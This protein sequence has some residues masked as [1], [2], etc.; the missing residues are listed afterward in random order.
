MEIVLNG[1][2]K[3][4]PEE[5]SI[6]ELLEHIGM[7]KRVAIFVNDTQLLGAEYKTTIIHEYDKVRIFKPLSG[8]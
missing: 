1:E 7:S 4:I 2:K 6:L 5:F 8:G 3:D